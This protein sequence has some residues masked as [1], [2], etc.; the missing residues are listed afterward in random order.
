MST[1]QI[2]TLIVGGGQAG[3]AQSE[4]LYNLKLPHLILEKER[5]AESWRT[6]R[7]DSL[8]TNGPV[9]HDRFPTLEFSGM[10][11]NG[12]ATKQRVVA[13]LEEV[14]QKINAPIRCGVKVNNLYKEPTT[15]RWVAETTSG[16]IKSTN[17]VVAT[18][19]FQSP[20]IPKIVPQT[21]GLTQ[22][23]SCDYRNPKQLPDG[24][25]LVVGSGSS[26][27]QIAEELLLA[28]RTVYLS[29]GPHD[30]PPRSY[31]GHDY[32]WWLGVLGKWAAK[33]PQPGTEHVTIAVSGAY[34]GKTVDFRRFAANGMQLLGMTREFKD[35]FLH[36]ESDLRENLDRGD[37]NYLSVLSE[38]DK[39]VA[40]NN[41]DLPTEEEARIMY[42][43]P[44]CVKNP[45]LHLNLTEA[46]IKSIVWATG[47]ARDFSWMKAN[48][49]GDDGQPNHNCGVS[50]EPGI[51]FLGLPWLSMRGSSFIWGVWQDAKHI[52]E[53]IARR[54]KDL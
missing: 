47:F 39:Y 3:L 9:W 22:I 5:I 49:F 33:A 6:A 26:G 1:E 38:A 13:Y 52:A 41:L 2:D 4:H 20:I 7:W 51:Y 14:V 37:S 8:V 45:I 24:A 43:D 54:K 25:V 17:V 18:G 50:N 48:V 53:H 15:N 19:P 21:S 30:R 29:I 23:H 35:G 36:L 42:P 32:C 10:S 31:R 44:A 34:G 27:A 40:E 46:G 11:P 16:I 12:F 28:N